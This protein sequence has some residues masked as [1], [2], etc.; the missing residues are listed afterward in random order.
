M[1]LCDYGCGQEAKFQF[2]NGKWCCS[3]FTSRCPIIIQK[4]IERNTGQKRS[5]ETG[6][7]ISLGQMGKKNSPPIF[8]ENCNFNCC[9]GCGNKAQYYFPI[10]KKYCCSDN[11]MKCPING[12]KA[13][14]R[15]EGHSV[16]KETRKKISK[17]IIKLNIENEEYRIKQSL[18]RTYKTSD[19]KKIYPF[20]TQ[21]EDIR[22]DPKTGLIQVRC[23]N[24]N[25]K[26]SKEKG[27][28]FT[29]SGIQLYERVRQLEK[30]YG[31][32]GCYLYCSQKCK[33]E[34]D[35][36]NVHG[37]PFKDT[38]KPYTYQEKQIWRK[39]VLKEDKNLC[40]YCGGKAIDVH[41]IKPVKTHPHLALDPDNGISFCKECH[42]K[43]GHKTG[44]ECSTGNLAKKVQQ[45][46]ILGAQI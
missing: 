14:K 34:C 13:S 44:T 12:K 15:L 28:W 2:K 27:G 38:T 11:H 30:D 39:I 25:C 46:C 17:K 40:Q 21:I 36:Y 6:K 7:K 26:N 24:H 20:F 45:G 29:P 42:Y 37:D 8:I 18:T 5:K 31:N 1:K 43:F 33:D 41:H 35:L 16:S 22:D 4:G 3:N 9:Y 32:G 19:Y 10:A 23:K